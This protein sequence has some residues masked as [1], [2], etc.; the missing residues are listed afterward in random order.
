M[1]QNKTRNTNS[2]FDTQ[3]LGQISF[4]EWCGHHFIFSS[5]F[6]L[7]IKKTFLVNH[8]ANFI[9]E[10]FNFSCFSFIFWC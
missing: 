5:P 3:V 4:H 1:N 8:V 6:P 2:I 9:K 7:A 10:M